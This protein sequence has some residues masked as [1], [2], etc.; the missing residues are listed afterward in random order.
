MHDSNLKS[1]TAAQR[2]HI[3]GRGSHHPHVQ[4]AQTVVADTVLDAAEHF[5][6]ALDERDV[7][8]G[9]VRVDELEH[10]H[11]EDERILVRGVGAMVFYG[12]R[13]TRGTSVT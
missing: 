10:G 9:N 2:R 5:I 6:V 3:T 8:E 4:L 13:P 1:G 7:E 11:L 12:P